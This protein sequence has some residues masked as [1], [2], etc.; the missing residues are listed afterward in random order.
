MRL[1][2][3]LH[4]HSRFSRATSPQMSLEALAHWAKIK[5]IGLL[6]TGD[7]THPQWV[8][9]LKDG[10]A[11]EGNGLYRYDDVRFMLT[12]EISA[13]WSQDGRVRK[14]HLLVL[15]P[16]FE[17]VERINRDLALI[18]NLA[19]DGRP[20]LGISAQH[21]AEIVWDA[22]ERAEIIPAHVWTPWFS[23]FGSR[24][25][26]DSLEDCFGPYTKRIFAVETGLSSDPPMNRRLSALDNLTLI[27]N[28]DAHSPSKLGREATL[29]DLPEPSYESVIEAMK[30]RDPSRFLGTIEFYPQ[31]GKYHYDGHRKCG[32]V[33][34]PREAIA[35]DNTCPV[36]G[37]PL[38]IGVLHRVE[39][40]ADRDDKGASVVC[41]PYTSL[42]PLEEILSQVLEVGV[43]T[44]TVS[45]EYDR[46][47]EEFGSE[48]RI[49]LDLPRKEMEGRVPA[50]ILRG[51]MAVRS[52]DVEVIPGYD[53]LY[54][55]VR[56]PFDAA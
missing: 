24:S 35:R 21:L 11:P 37:K 25:G 32:V 53:G 26:F 33:L 47:I 2:A 44:K 4:I 23:V 5:G 19:S 29:F 12:A 1:I 17:S 10:L 46:L 43:K 14:V 34:S 15:T 16:S 51:I 39:E 41:P 56:I 8:K 30:T 9:E 48:F 20:I 52:G 28:S 50:R 40:L 7:F 55:Q 49:L 36:C 6:G 13:I 54:G 38:T 22:D 3:D 27:S 42:V 18:G 45:R 31:E